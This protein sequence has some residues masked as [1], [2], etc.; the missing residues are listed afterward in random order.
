MK[1]IE[2]LI[3]ILAQ[4]RSWSPRVSWRVT[5]TA[6]ILATLVKYFEESVQCKVKNWIRYFLLSQLVRYHRNNI[7][8]GFEK[9]FL[10]FRIKHLFSVAMCIMRMRAWWLT[11]VLC[12]YN[13]EPRVFFWF[14]WRKRGQILKIGSLLV[15][16]SLKN[17]SLSHHLKKANLNHEEF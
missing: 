1:R 12:S 2:G 8:N 10:T 9:G 6:R 4:P 7:Y 16:S 13:L 15:P 17:A 3:A 5:I 14:L 11:R